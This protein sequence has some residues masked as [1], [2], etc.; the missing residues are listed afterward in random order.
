[1]LDHL[2]QAERT[3]I[4]RKL[5]QAWKETNADHA[6]AQLRALAKHLEVKQPGAAASLLEGLEETLT[7]TRL[8]LSSSLLRTLNRPTRSN[9]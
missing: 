6:Q 5:D 7:V 2:P 4:G 1:V 9:P 8:G 3:F